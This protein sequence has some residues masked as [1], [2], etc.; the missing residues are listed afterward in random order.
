MPAYHHRFANAAEWSKTFD[1]PSRNAWQKAQSVI[2]AMEIAPGA[3]V[4][5]IGV[6]HR[7]PR[8]S[9]DT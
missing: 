8:L 4:A 3:T 5:D 7:F 1:D 9:P 2:D 6:R